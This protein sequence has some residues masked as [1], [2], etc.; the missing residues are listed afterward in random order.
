MCSSAHCWLLS[1]HSTGAMA[2]HWTVIVD[3]FT[4]DDVS[5]QH[6]Q[7]VCTES[8]TATE[9][10][11]CGDWTHHQSRRT[12]RVISRFCIHKLGLQKLLADAGCAILIFPSVTGCIINVWLRKKSV[13]VSIPAMPMIINLILSHQNGPPF[14]IYCTLRTHCL[15]PVK[16]FTAF[17]RRSAWLYMCV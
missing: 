13:A 1:T 8:E 4:V 14:N 3:E 15:L 9:C 5:S 11:C 12:D 10:C 17:H 2:M 6:S 16:S 7:R